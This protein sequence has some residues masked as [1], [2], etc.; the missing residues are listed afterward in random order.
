MF[1]GTV[2]LDEYA[3]EHRLSP[4]VEARV[5]SEREDAGTV[6]SAPSSGGIA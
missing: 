6:R 5:E 4:G 1:T 2:P 3:K